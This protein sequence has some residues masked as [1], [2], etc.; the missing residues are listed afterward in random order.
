[1]TAEKGDM[2]PGQG[3]QKGNSFWRKGLQARKEQKS[4]LEDFFKL[5]ASGGIEAYAEKLEDLSNGI[6][7][8]K[9]E[10]SFMSKIE[11]LMQY[12]KAKQTDVTSGG[13]KIESSLIQ[14]VNADD[15]HTD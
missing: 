2:K 3:F 10:M 14:F 13:E 8:S 15:K 11:T 5:L 6:D 12:I 9:P 4:M 1:M 7:L